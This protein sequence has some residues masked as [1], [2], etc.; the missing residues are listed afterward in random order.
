MKDTQVQK[1]LAAEKKRQKSVINLVA[2]ENYVSDDVL[3]ALGTVTTN[4]YAEG[5]SGARYYGG[6]EVI[7]QIEDLAI[8]R[9]LKLFKLNSKKWGVNVQPHSGS[10]ANIAVYQALV[11]QGGKIMGMTL[12][13]GGHLTHGHTVSFSGKFW[14]QVPYGVNEKTE[15]I[16]YEELIKIAKK[17]K[18]ALV[19]AGYSAY[20]R[21]IN[22]KKMRE[23]AD[24]AGAYLMVDMAHISGLIAGGQHASPFKYADVV[25]TTTHKV[26]RGPRGGMIYSRHDY[27]IGKKT[28]K[29]TSKKAPLTLFE[30]I[31]KS[32]FPGMQG[33]P[34]MNQIAALAVAL[35]E[36]DSASFKK[37]TEQVVKNSKALSGEL[38]NLGW[39][40]T[41][42][43]T[44]NHV[45]LVDVWNNGEGITGK[46][47][48]T[49]LEK[50]GIIVNMNT[51]PFDTRS[52]FNPSG[53]RLGTAAETTRGK[54]EKD[55][56]ILARQID[57][58]LR[59]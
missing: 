14:E 7:D 24:A 56:I 2:S 38:K 36:A 1:L 11:P 34:H 55:M 15:K 39:R 45:F 20:P 47:A 33:G 41:S 22:F 37:Y 40:I 49:R 53:L 59:K 3:A 43:G 19:V 52:P 17:E 8:E 25:T 16:D 46:E 26:L 28:P 23:V 27:G 31:Q 51:I 18:P 6:N 30:K 44:D 42:G 29:T 12:S 13:H 58:I 50:K 57:K 9:A 4:K 10:P 21:K 54:K 32:V 35:K 5:Y 48:S